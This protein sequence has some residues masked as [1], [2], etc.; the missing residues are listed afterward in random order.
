[1]G[2]HFLT[3]EAHGI[4]EALWSHQA[5]HVRLH[6]DSRKTQ[7]IPQLSQAIG[8]GVWRPLDQAILERRLIRQVGQVLGPLGAQFTTKRAGR[9]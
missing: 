6:E 7:L 8:D 9:L 1:L 4:V 3:E 2:P 5:P